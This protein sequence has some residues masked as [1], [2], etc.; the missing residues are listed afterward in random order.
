MLCGNRTRLARLEAWSLCRSAKSTVCKRKE[1]ESN[2]QGREARPGSSGVPSPIGLPFRSHVQSCGGRNRTC[3]RAV[4][5]R[6]VRTSTGPTASSQDDWI[7]TSVLVFPEHAGC[8]TSP[9]PEVERPAGIE[10]TLPPWQG[11]RLPL[12]HGRFKRFKLSKIIRAPG[13]TRTDVAALRVR[14]LRR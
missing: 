12:H 6:L 1:R 13:R 5:S 2:S 14:S 3:V 10:P 8:Q 9:R 7:R 4:N 11:S